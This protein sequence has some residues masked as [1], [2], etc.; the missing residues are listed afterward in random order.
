MFGEL[1]LL[2]NTVEYQHDSAA[3]VQETHWKHESAWRAS[4]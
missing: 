4:G 1:I 2:L 3:I